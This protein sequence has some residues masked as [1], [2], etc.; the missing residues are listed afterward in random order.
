[1]LRLSSS[2]SYRTSRL[3]YY[4][5]FRSLERPTGQATHWHIQVNADDSLWRCRATLAH[6][7]KHIL[8][9]PF[10]E[11]LYPEW[12]REA[13]PPDLAER[14]CDYFAGCLLV[15]RAWLYAAWD[16]GVQDP[17]ALASRFDVSERLIEVRMDQTRVRARPG[18]A[19]HRLPR[20]PHHD[21]QRSSGIVRI[22]SH[23][24]Y[25]ARRVATSTSRAALRKITR[26]ER[27]V[28]R[29]IRPSVINA[30]A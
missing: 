18:D 13:T 21:Y 20:T 17:T 16:E 5:I 6:E 26:G 12:P 25:D 11:Q 3:T 29:N 24:I 28:Y 23:H 30:T 2:P 15:P 1:V 14:V 27:D 8:D 4:P 7:Y 10:R 19:K 22:A 9:D